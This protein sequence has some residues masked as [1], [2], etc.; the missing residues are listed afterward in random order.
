M[1]KKIDNK[2][3]SKKRGNPNWKKGGPSPNPAGAPKRGQSWKEL[4]NEIGNMTPLEAANYCKAIAGQ[5]A[6]IGANVTLKEAVTLRVY[7]ALLFEPDARLLNSVMD[8]DEGK[9]TQPMSV[10]TW[11]DKVITLLREKKVA[12]EDVIQE[13]GNDLATELFVGAGIPRSEIREV[14]P[15]SQPA[16]D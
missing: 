8:R 10:E 4:W 12:P 6:S 5:L 1:K 9:V 2:A 7:A 11:R 3:T 16:G 13:F 14:T 15:T